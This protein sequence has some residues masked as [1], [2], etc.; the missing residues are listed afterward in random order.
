[1]LVK[2]NAKTN[3]YLYVYSAQ[4]IWN[5]IHYQ[6][7]ECRGPTSGV[8]MFIKQGKQKQSKDQNLQR[9]G[10]QESMD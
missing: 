1:M 9:T 2:C 3:L 8:V 7:T 10:R 6:A 4:F 5:T